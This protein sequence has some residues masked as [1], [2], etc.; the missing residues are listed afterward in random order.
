VE[1]ALEAHPSVAEAAVA[2]VPHE[3]WGER[4]TAWVVVRDGH[5]F[6]EAALIAHA[7][8]RLAGYKCPK[9]VFRLAALPR[10]HVGK[11]VR[12]ALG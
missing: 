7:R 10:N 11:V 1:I 3:R 6:D 8:T 9:R 2:G 12:S 4:V 5:E